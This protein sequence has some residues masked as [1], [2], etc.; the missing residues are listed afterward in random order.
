MTINTFNSGRLHE[1]DITQ[2]I[3]AV[4]DLRPGAIMRRF[5]LRTQP[6]KRGPAGFY[7]PLSVYGHFGR[8]EL[9]LPWEQTDLAEMLRG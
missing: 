8:P 7:R 5:A 6:A 4:L 9:D 1:D 2:R 3:R